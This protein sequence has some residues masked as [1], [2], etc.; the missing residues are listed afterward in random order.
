MKKLHAIVLSVILILTC[1]RAHLFAADDKY[2]KVRPAAVAGMFYPDAPDELR[3]MVRTF[4]KDARGVKVPGKVRGLVSP[5]AGY[6][7]SGVVAAAGYRQIDPST[8]TVI[9]LGPSHRVPLRAP[10][11]PEVLAYWTPLGDV[12]LARFASTLRRSR[13]FESVPEAHLKEWA[14]EVQLPFLQGILKEFEI[15]PIL[16]NSSDPKALAKTLV[17]YIDDDT[18]VVASSDL[19][20]YYSYETAVALDRI[21]T[22]A[23]SECKFSDMPICEACGKQAV[24]TLMHIAKI[25]GWQGTLVDYRNSGD[26]AGGRNRVVGY[27]SIAFVDRRE[28]TG[29]MKKTLSNQD[30]KALLKLARSAIEA[31]LVKGTKVDRPA[32]VSPALNESKGCFVTLHKHGQLRGCIGT[33]EPICPLLECVEK[34]AQSAAFHDPRFPP[35]NADEL[36]DIDIEISVLSVPEALNFKDGEDLKRKLKP[37]VHGVI[38]SRGIHRSTFL[39]QVWEQLPDTEQFLEHLCLKGGMSPNAWQDPQTKVE[40]YEAEVFGEN[41]LK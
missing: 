37:N 17:P 16:M 11:I 26:T 33:I 2:H 35:L 8:R 32:Q 28:V 22:R 12:H 29:T 31:R 10:S 6:I 23:I 18:L 34:N 27:A 24:L 36:K 25:K 38:L 19:S 39:P 40:V 7:Y 1:V 9:L 15:V 14:L 4:F 41:D 20:H 21:C 30:R 13:G 3:Q 5:H